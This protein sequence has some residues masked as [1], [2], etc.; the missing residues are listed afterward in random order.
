MHFNDL[1]EVFAFYDIELGVVLNN[2]ELV[3]VASLEN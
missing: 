1:F 3:G 2:T